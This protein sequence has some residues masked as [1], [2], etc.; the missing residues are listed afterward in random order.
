MNDFIKVTA[1]IL[2]VLILGIILKSSRPEISLV[3]IIAASCV[4]LIFVLTK[5]VSPVITFIS[6]LCASS[7]LDSN[8]VMILVKS[9]GIGMICEI[10]TLV[11]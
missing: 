5:Y 4:A 2:I 1:V 9:A 8:M 7:G 6:E 10:V 11:C 3:L